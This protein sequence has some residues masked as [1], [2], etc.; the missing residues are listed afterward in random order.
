[1]S[2][3]IKAVSKCLTTAQIIMLK[4]P[5]QITSYRPISLLSICKLFKKLLMHP[6]PMICILRFQLRFRNQHST[7][8]QA[9]KVVTNIEWVLKENQYCSAV[10]LEIS[11]ASDRV[12]QQGLFHKMSILL[13][14][15]PCQLLLSSVYELISRVTYEWAF[16]QESVFGSLLY[17]KYTADIPTTE[18][19]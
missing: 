17:S 18:R 13:P 7:I 2:A 12:G 6:K 9:H 4:K 19:I 16:T 5:E 15:N 1:M 14:G 8:D 3:Q 11:Q 10:F